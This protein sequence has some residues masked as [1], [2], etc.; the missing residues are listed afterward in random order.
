[1]FFQIYYLRFIL[2]PIYKP[3]IAYAL[4]QQLALMILYIY[5]SLMPFISSTNAKEEENFTDNEYFTIILNK[6]H[7]KREILSYK[8]LSEKLNNQSEVVTAWQKN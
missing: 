2:A 3:S 6:D 4:V 5:V 1:M 7:N 8:T